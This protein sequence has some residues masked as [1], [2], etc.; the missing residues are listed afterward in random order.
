MIFNKSGNKKQYFTL[1]AL[2]RRR[3]DQKKNFLW[4]INRTEKLETAAVSRTMAQQPSLGFWDYEK[5]VRKI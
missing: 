1:L 4:T 3:T 2:Y 5:I